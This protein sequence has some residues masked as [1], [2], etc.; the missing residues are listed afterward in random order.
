[1]TARIPSRR[2]RAAWTSPAD[3]AVEQARDD[4]QNARVVLDSIRRRVALR[5][6]GAA[7]LHVAECRLDSALNA[8]NRIDKLDPH[9]PT[10]DPEGDDAA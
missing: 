8:L 2:P 10:A 9:H 7:A 6:D 1:M 3:P 4:V 5:L